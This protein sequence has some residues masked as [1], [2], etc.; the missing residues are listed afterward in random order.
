[1]NEKVSRISALITRF[2]NNDLDEEGR[3]E[4]VAWK[5]LDE[6]NRRFFEKMT[7][8]E[9]LFN[10]VSETYTAE[11]NIYNQIK[12]N[13]PEL[14][15]V[16]TGKVMRMQRFS[17]R[18][19]TAAAAII[20]ILAGAYVW[21]GRNKERAVVKNEGS[22]VAPANDRPPGTFKA[23]L[24]LA[25]GLT[26]VLDSASIGMLAQQ[27]AT[28]VI[29][30]DGQLVYA[31]HDNNTGEVLYN[32]LATSRGQMY[33]L[34]L[35][36]N[37]RVWLNSASSIRF[38]VSFA[39]NE[40]RIEVTGEAYF[41]IAHDASRPFTVSV[42]GAAITVLGTKF[43]VNAYT[44]EGPLK[45]TLLEGSVRIKNAGSL[46]L[47][48]PGQQAIVTDN[49]IKTSMDI[50]A[51]K[52]VAWKNNRFYFKNDDIETVMRHIA[53]WYDVDVEFKNVPDVKFNAKI[54][55]NVNASVVFEALEAT[56]EVHFQIVGKK[57][58]V[59]K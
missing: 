37:S 26:I 43:N 45:T 31:G 35:S 21:L 34:V 14:S 4:L 54:S 25:N 47:L 40:R 56:G 33:P 13:V 52:I 44:N 23:R 12:Q 51:D 5:E 20:L 41:E 3:K 10:A 22:I 59:S 57:V 19:L 27:G 48:K 18:K 28:Q 39:K 9:Q 32:T 8:E 49:G 36:D 24:T 16:E 11:Q 55:R 15:E 46:A 38:P 17:W 42:N 58:T 6:D 1:M 7:S 53:R 50:D 30:K 2:L 29:N